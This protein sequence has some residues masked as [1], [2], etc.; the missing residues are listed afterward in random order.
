[1]GR[2]AR[3]A[4]FWTDSALVFALPFLAHSGFCKARGVKRQVGNDEASEG[5]L[6]LGSSGLPGS[7]LYPRRHQAAPKPDLLKGISA[8]YDSADPCQAGQRPRSSTRP[9]VLSIHSSHLWAAEPT[10]PR[11]PGS[12]GAQSEGHPC[13]LRPLWRHSPIGIPQALAPPPAERTA[14]NRHRP[15]P[16]PAN[17]AK[18]CMEVRG[19]RL[20]LRSGPGFDYSVVAPLRGFPEIPGSSW[21]DAGPSASGRGA[22]TAARAPRAPL[23]HLRLAFLQGNGVKWHAQGH[24]GNH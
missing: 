15:R 9:C 13:G 6:E 2:A 1:M 12:C 21:A 23:F 8:N 5:A 14:A 10:S 18:S 16:Q 3:D 17:E 11:E 22:E 4:A 20:R 24:T 7:V 19:D